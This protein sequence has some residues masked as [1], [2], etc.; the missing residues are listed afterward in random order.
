MI[1]P[2]YRSKVRDAVENLAGQFQDLNWDFRPVTTNGKTE[3]ISQWLGDPSED[4]MVVSFHGKRYIEKY[5]RQDFFFINFVCQNGYDVLSSKYNNQLHLNE[6]DCYI[7]Q[8]Y[9]GYALKID[10][11]EEVIMVGLHIKKEL[12]YRE[13]L[14]ALAAD[15]ALFHFFLDPHT[16]RF[17]DEYIRLSLD[18]DNVIWA[19]LYQM[20]VEY[21]NK[22][23]NTQ[24]ILHSIMLTLMMYISR[25]YSRQYSRSQEETSP[26]FRMETYIETHSDTVTLKSL[27]AHFGYHPNYVSRF[28]HQSTGRT[29]S[30]ILL[31]KRM[32]KAGLLLLNTDLTIEKIAA[33]L[34]YKNNSNF[35]KAFREYYHTSP[36]EFTAAH[37]KG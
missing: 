34:G 8:P 23:E 13:Y 30:E 14:G 28:L 12:F 36:R 37:R 26:A 19:M 32:E 20:A 22:S 9:S 15:T 24:T 31:E 7:G 5:H 27:A 1:Y 21:A 33:I 35:Y 6:G 10:G 2:D 3:L 29:F 25:E 17:S 11:D 16:N 4:I 18:P